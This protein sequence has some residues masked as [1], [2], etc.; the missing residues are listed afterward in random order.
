[1]RLSTLVLALSFSS[2]GAVKVHDAASDPER[3]AVV[4]GLPL[5]VEEEVEEPRM[6]SALS[7]MLLAFD[8][9]SAFKWVNNIKIPTIR[10]RLQKVRAK[11]LFGDKK[12]AIITGTSSGL[13]K[14]TAAQL[15]ATG[16]Y[17]V[18]G[19]VRDLEK[20]KKVAAEEGF[21][22]KLF[23][24]M[25]ADLNDFTS[26][27][28]FVEELKEWKGSKAVDR[29][30]CN[31]GVYL[32]S[33]EPSFSEDGIE[34]TAQVNYLSHFML[35]SHL[36]EDLGKSPDPR[37]IFV[38]S[39]SANDNTLAG[40]GVYPK[41]DL[42]ELDGLKVGMKSP[43]SMLD[44]YNFDSHKAYKDSKLALMMLSNSLH[45]MY[46]KQ[47]GI[48]FSSIYPGC[49]SESQLFR[50]KPEWFQKYFAA[51]MKNL[52]GAHVSQEEAGKRLFQVAHDVRC[53]KS[54]IYWS[55][56]QPASAGEGGGW[57]SIYEVEPS[58]K[59]LDMEKSSDLFRYSAAVTG[60]R[61]PQ[62]NVPKSPCPTLKVIGA[63]TAAS[64]AKEDAKR[65][66]V[67]GDGIVGGKTSKILAGTAKVADTLVGNTIGR[68]GKLAQRLVLGA[69]PDKAK[70]GSFQ[71]EV[72]NQEQDDADMRAKA[73]EVL[74]G[75]GMRVE[76]EK[77]DEDTSVAS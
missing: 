68:A 13:G 36:L 59:I 43:V 8:P 49:M 28:K 9:V 26:V 31:A 61:W 44:G 56:N 60:T 69:V 45:H 50:H 67:A 55:W 6:M 46:H 25:E 73:E 20:M 52:M 47:T 5:Q 17:H 2:A 72:G 4:Q 32:P 34:Q 38:G 42:Q 70:Q 76:V 71:T 41:A 37:C 77:K 39:V 40:G 48:A 29:L 58:D 7:K 23:T 57:D 74:G 19:A 16:K 63:I 21:D 66:K 54:G 15:L 33:E 10:G 22:A 65:M 24:P 30:I 75:E 14:E 3:I 11:R 53:A 12:L 18:V 64:N 27:G 1:M 62:A 51:C 35:T